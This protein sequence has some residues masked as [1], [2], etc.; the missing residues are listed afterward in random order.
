MPDPTSIFASRKADTES[1]RLRRLGAR[2]NDH[3]A[4]SADVFER[5]AADAFS[6]RASRLDIGTNA[7]RGRP[8]LRRA[9][10]GAAS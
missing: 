1:Y 8:D 6:A 3:R 2:H 9:P 5:R 4:S 7:A 10:A